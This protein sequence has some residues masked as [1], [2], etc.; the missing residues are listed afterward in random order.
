MPGGMTFP[1]TWRNFIAI[2]IWVIGMVLLLF[3]QACS[4]W[5]ICE[6]SSVPLVILL[7]II[8]AAVALSD[9]V[10]IRRAARKNLFGTAKE[11]E[12]T[13]SDAE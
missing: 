1:M 4:Q 12:T 10:R 3:Q 2:A 7:G 13:S 11:D 6:K 8:G 5:A 9:A